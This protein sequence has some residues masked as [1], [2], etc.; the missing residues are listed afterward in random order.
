MPSV[1]VPGQSNT[2]ACCEPAAIANAPAGDAI[3]MP[4]SSH[5]T[6]VIAATEIPPVPGFASVAEPCRLV[7]TGAEIT[8]TC[9][10][11]TSSPP[12]AAYAVAAAATTIAAETARAR[13]LRGA[14]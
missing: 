5:G 12:I 6:R 7:C 9:G 8:A 1:G 4:G 2:T 13:H 10:D 11:A 14:R 3:V